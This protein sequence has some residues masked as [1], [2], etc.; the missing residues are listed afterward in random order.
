MYIKMKDKDELTD[1]ELRRKRR[2]RSQILAYAI[3]A[4]LVIII[5][6]AAYFGAG[7]LISSVKKYNEKVNDAIESAESSVANDLENDA[8]DSDTQGSDN[9]Y[10]YADNDALSDL[11][12]SLVQDM[13]LEEK[14]AGMFIISPESI[15]GVSTVI[16]AGEGTKNALAENPVGGFIYSANNYKSEEQFK[17]MLSKTIEYSKYPMFLAVSQECGKDTGFGVEETPTAMEISDTDSAVA[18][19]TKIAQKLVSYGINMNLAPVSA[20]VSEDSGSELA[21]HT[22]GSDAATASPL[23]NASV[24]AMQ[25]VELNAVLMKFPGANIE[26]KSIEEFNNTDFVIYQS[27]ISNG[28]DCIMVTNEKAKGITGDDTPAALSSVVITDTLRNVLGFKGVVITDSLNSSAITAEY[29]AG[30]AAVEAVVAG[31]DM[32]LEPEDYKKAYD[33]IIQ[34][35]ADGT[36]TTERIDESVCRIYKVK[37]K[38]ALE[39]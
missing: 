30:S 33:G 24:K 34:A 23:I 25:D 21:G 1:R 8:S 14:V 37:Y 35:V 5:V 11:V 18:A 36:I 10:D 7:K 2:I 26:N 12:K 29:D 6:V 3:L 13:T 31:A 19:Y 28:T 9:I 39:Q 17:E 15:T 22:F 27:A 16:Q 20:V 38:N 32:I 4:L